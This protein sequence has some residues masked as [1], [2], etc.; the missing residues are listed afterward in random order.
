[1]IPRLLGRASARLGRPRTLSLVGGLALALALGVVFLPGLFVASVFRP[2]A[3]VAAA[4]AL[5]ALFGL[6]AGGLGALALGREATGESRAETWVPERVPERAHYDDHRTTG[7]AIDSA[8]AVDP[9]ADADERER[10]AHQRTVARGRIR[11]R[12]IEA[13]AAAERCD[14]E[15]AAE[16][17]DAGT[18]T[19]DPR[20]AAFLG[21]ATHAPLGLRIRDWASGER[22]ERWATRAVAE[23][24]SLADG[25]GRR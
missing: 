3:D 21:G 1:M 7:S 20:A 9:E 11:E 17:V 6:A 14:R 5:V 10:L 16:R 19:D 18:W 22:F 23:T 13:I 12:A 2:V 25:E 4:P 15:R 24:E 8:L